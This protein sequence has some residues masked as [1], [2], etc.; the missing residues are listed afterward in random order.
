MRT[1]SRGK[2]SGSAVV[3]FALAVSV[4]IPAYIWMVMLGVDLR[5]L[6]QTNQ[7]CRDAGH[8][9]ARNVDFSQSMNKDFV[10]RLGKSMGMADNSGTGVVILSKV[11]KAGTNTCSAVPSCTNLDKLV[12]TERFVIGNAA[13]GVSKLGT[14]S[15]IQSN[16]TILATD[17]LKKSSCIATNMP[18]SLSAY[19]SDGDTAYVAE[20]MFNSFWNKARGNIYAKM[21]F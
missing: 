16:G 11:V 9:Y 4:L 17:Y 7:M 1:A 6:L 3:E 20:A 18:A 15:T 10:I 12:V 19:M 2:R 14:P 8:M 21:F 13:V 5:R